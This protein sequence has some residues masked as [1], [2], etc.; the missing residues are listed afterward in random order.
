MWWNKDKTLPKSHVVYRYLSRELLVYFSIAFLFFFAVFFVNQILLTI[1]E[2]LK[3]RVP[4]KDVLRLIWY[5]LPSIVATAA[6]FATLVGFLM[7]LGRFVS[8]N[9]ILI[10]RST[11]HK[12]IQIRHPYYKTPMRNFCDEHMNFRNNL[13]ICHSFLNTNILYHKIEQIANGFRT[14]F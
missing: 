1:E 6:P 13:F 4:L 12:Y 10:L 9:E 5:S 3:Q 2:L 8:D 11:G 7:C 14:F